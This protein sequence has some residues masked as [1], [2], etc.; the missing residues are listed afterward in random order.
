MTKKDFIKEIR[1]LNNTYREVIGG[2]CV[3]IYINNIYF[4]Y[5][6]IRL[7]FD[8]DDGILYIFAR[9]Q[10]KIIAGVSYIDLIIG[11]NI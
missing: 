4:R 11:F 3:G 8:D 9:N 10:N 6:H 5:E 7:C 2:K 1:K